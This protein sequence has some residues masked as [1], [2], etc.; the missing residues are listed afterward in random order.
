MKL[1]ALARDSK[2]LAGSRPALLPGG[3]TGVLLLHGFTGTPRDLA[4]LARRLHGSGF[5]VSLPRLPGHGT[6]GGDFLQSGWR[7][8]LRAAADAWMDIAGRCEKV[9]LVGY[10]MGG[11]LAAMLAAHFPVSRLV[12]VAPA[13]RTKNPLL[14]LS[15]LLGLFLRRT[16]RRMD[17]STVAKD[18]ESQSLAR[19]YWHW[20][21]PRQASSLLWLQRRANR[22]LRAVTA[23]TLTI[24]GTADSSV[25]VSVIAHVEKRIAARARHHVVLEG[26]RHSIFAGPAADTVIDETV[27]WLTRPDAPATVRT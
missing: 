6:N 13:L 16:A 10:S 19:E 27:R 4:G 21:Y 20:R 14:P 7:D 15:P 25:P 26:A 9:H 12:L 18:E 5:T 1:S 23:D 3:T 22:A 11:V 17:P 24:V 2:T 8:W